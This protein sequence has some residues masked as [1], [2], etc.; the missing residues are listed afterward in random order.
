M[1]RHGGNLTYANVIATLALFIAM[2]G[3]ALAATHL[4]RNSVGTQQLKNNAVT[5]AKIKNGVITSSKVREG[6]LLRQDFAFGQLSAGPQG[7][8]GERGERG[9]QGKPGVTK[10]VTRY[11]KEV[12]I[13][14]SKS[15]ASYAACRSGEAVAGGGYDFPAGRPSSAAYSITF[16]RPSLEVI[17]EGTPNFPPP[18]NGNPATGW[19]AGVENNTASPFKFR[20]YVMCAST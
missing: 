6:S 12:E 17:E 10:V 11:G 19:G 20:A 7:A 8:P 14:I 16:D 15:K 1:R 4:G 18:A 3:G 2:G 13:P 5:W 9:E